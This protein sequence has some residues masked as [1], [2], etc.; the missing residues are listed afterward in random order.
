MTHISVTRVVLK[1]YSSPPRFAVFNICILTPTSSDVMLNQRVS[2]LSVWEQMPRI[3]SVFFALILWPPSQHTAIWAKGAH[4]HQ[5]E[6]SVHRRN[7]PPEEFWG[8]KAVSTLA[9]FTTKTHVIKAH[10]LAHFSYIS[11]Q[12]RKFTK[13]H[14]LDVNLSTP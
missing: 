6:Q 3:T 14:Y 7:R 11:N 9:E 5:H 2:D 4:R 10:V 8:P 1:W 13:G 12:L